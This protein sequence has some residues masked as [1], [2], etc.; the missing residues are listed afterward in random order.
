[1]QREVCAKAVDF[2]GAATLS[3]PPS[4]DCISASALAH[5]P[6]RGQVL[7][8]AANLGGVGIGPLIAGLLGQ[9]VDARGGSAGAG[10]RRQVIAV[11]RRSGIRRL[12]LRWL[13]RAVGRVPGGREGMR[14]DLITVARATQRFALRR[15]SLP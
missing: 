13:L 7:A 8:T 4:P 5:R 1:M 11:A 9:Y 14:Q 3:D 2:V 15:K 12:R 6:K 10:G